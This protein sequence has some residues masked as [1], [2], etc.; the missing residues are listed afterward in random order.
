M[1]IKPSVRP[2]TPLAKGASVVPVR[3]TAYCRRWT[4]KNDQT[5]LVLNGI[6]KEL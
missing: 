6:P 1:P 2:V 5:T 4:G 3:P